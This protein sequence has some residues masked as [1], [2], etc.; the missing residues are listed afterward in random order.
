[1]ALSYECSSLRYALLLSNGG[2]EEALLRGW[3]AGIVVEE[4]DGT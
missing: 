3:D 2:V 1:M 4:D